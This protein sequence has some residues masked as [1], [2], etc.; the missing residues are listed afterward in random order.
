M[1]KLALVL[2]LVAACKKENVHVKVN[3]LT[4]AGPTVECTIEQDKGK[5]EVDVCWDFIATCAD[6]IEVKAERTCTKVKDG[7]TSTVTIPTEKLANVDK[8][9]GTPTAKIANLTI[10]GEAG[11][12]D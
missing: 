2:L 3:C 1:K 4:K 9:Q 11:K 10:N 7:G 6:N 8:C 5:S 12:A